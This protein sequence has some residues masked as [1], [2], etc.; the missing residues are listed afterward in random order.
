MT[1]RDGAAV[2]PVDGVACRLQPGRKTPR[3]LLI[4]LLRDR[5]GVS[6]VELGLATALILAP[7]ASVFDFGMAFS[8][9]IKLQQAVQAGAQYASMNVWDGANSPTAITNVVTN[10]LPASLQGG[11]TVYGDSTHTAPFEACY[12]PTGTTGTYLTSTDSLS[13]CGTT[14]CADG[15]VSG[16]YVTVAGSLTY[17]PIAPYSSVFMNNPQTLTASSVVRVQ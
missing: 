8:Q 3:Q 2:A 7:L 16:Y 6:A 4:Q 12:C 17:T 14:A 11:L 1:R 5:D 13:S 15:E 9:Q 10:A